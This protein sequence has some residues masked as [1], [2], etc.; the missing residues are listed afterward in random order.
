MLKRIAEDF[1]GVK[2]EMECMGCWYNESGEDVPGLV[3]TTELFHCHQDYAN[4]IPGFVI[5]TPRRHIKSFDEFTDEEATEFIALVRKIRKAQR[6]VLGIETIYFVQE[7][8]TKHHFHVWFM[9]C[10][11]WM[12]DVEKFGDRISSVRPAS[13]YARENMKTPEIIAEVKV[14]AEKLRNFLKK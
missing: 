7:E 14:A 12:N 4:P 1:T 10:Y 5:L 13:R 3:L 2:R 9:P 8:S 6:E 11:E